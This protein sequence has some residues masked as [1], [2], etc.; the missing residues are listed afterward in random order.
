MQKRL[1]E[2]A[3]VTRHVPQ[4]FLL[5]S[6]MLLQT[7]V[8]HLLIQMLDYRWIIKRSSLFIEGLNNYCK[9]YFRRCLWNKTCSR[10]KFISASYALMKHNDSFIDSNIRKHGNCPMVT[11]T[12]AYLLQRLNYSCKFFYRR[13][14]S[15]QVCNTKLFTIVSYASTKHNMS[16][17]DSNIKIQ[18]VKRSSLF[19]TRTKLQLQKVL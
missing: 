10:K 11:N 17:I 19:I 3:T 8:C 2:D 12:L 4:I 1:S 18:T 9:K 5:V 13:C 14:H 7:T 16:F 6:V 15:N